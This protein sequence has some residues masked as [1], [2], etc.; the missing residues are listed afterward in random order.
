MNHSD[1]KRKQLTE[2]HTANVAPDLCEQLLAITHWMA[3]NDERFN[4]TIRLN[5]SLN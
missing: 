5:G 4:L 1:T 3:M 2:F